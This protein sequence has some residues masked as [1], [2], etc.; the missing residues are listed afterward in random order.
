MGRPGPE[1]IPEPFS[2]FI[3]KIIQSRKITNK[4]VKS[5]SGYRKIRGFSMSGCPHHPSPPFKT[6]FGSRYQQT[7]PKVA[8]KQA[9]FNPSLLVKSSFLSLG[10]N[11]EAVYWTLIDLY[12]TSKLSELDRSRLQLPKYA[13]FCSIFN[14]FSNSI[15]WSNS[16]SYSSVLYQRLY[17]FYFTISV[18]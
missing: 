4:N 14:T 17:P 15:F 10:P 1:S 7:D 3:Q 11:F 6:E 16:T 13:N 8:K 5:I 12:E 2:W 9:I 18:M